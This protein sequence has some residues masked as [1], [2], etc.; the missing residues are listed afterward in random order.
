MG[1]HYLHTFA[2]FYLASHK[3]HVKQVDLKDQPI[4]IDA[5]SFMY[6]VYD[7]LLNEEKGTDK[8]Q[9]SGNI[10]F[11]YDGYWRV[12]YNMLTKFKEK[13]SQVYVVFDGVF[14]RNANRRPDPERTSSLR[15]AEFNAHQKQLPILFL[16]QIFWVLDYLEVI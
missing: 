14:N 4:I 7:Q 1:P 13:C 16:H 3:H 11:D 15:F 12:L 2:Y 6:F 10:P 5:N 9:L 8:R